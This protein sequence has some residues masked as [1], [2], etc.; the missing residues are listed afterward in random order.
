[1]YD[2]DTHD[3]LETAREMRANYIRDAFRALFRRP[4]TVSAPA[5]AAHAG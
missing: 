5:Q 3:L 4:A 1:M 2:K